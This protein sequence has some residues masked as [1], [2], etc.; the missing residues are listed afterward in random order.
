MRFFQDLF[1]YDFYLDELY[2]Y[3]IVWLVSSS[4]KLTTW[5]D[6]YV[7]DG[8]VNLVSLATIFSGSALKYNTSG[9]S[10]FY[11]LTIVMGVSL[12]IWSI[13]SGQWQNILDYWA[14]FLK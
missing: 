6:R 11:L 13:L 7:I 14:N 1:A 4:S 5:F 10:Q 8:A 3:T 9:Q 2:S 12:L